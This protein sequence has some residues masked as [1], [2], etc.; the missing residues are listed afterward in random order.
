[1]DR[2]V[3]LHLFSKSRLHLSM[4]STVPGQFLIHSLASPN[5]HLCVSSFLKHYQVPPLTPS[6][7]ENRNS[8]TDVG[9]KT[10][11][12][13]KTYSYYEGKEGMNS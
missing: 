10:K 1:M 3:V 9:K 7:S 2:Q 13:N 11:Q 8:V 6:R 4:F 12:K 5:L